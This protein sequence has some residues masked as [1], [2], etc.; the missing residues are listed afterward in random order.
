MRMSLS[1]AE[2]T[3]NRRSPDQSSESA[4]Q[5]VLGRSVHFQDKRP[6]F[7]PGQT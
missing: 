1:L 7:Q 5:R 3:T 4:K 6:T 2:M